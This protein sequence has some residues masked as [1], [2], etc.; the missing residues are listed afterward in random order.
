M[1]QFRCKTCRQLQ[2]KYRLRGDKL[3]IEIKCYNDNVYNYFTIWLN[4]L[5]EDMDIQKKEE[6]TLERVFQKD[7]KNTVISEAILEN[8]G[9]EQ[10]SKNEN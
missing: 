3:E 5:S 9:F 7:G 4:R 8:T 1:S 10:K 2:F 6:K